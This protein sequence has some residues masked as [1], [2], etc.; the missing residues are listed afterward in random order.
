MANK[1]KVNKARVFYIILTLGL[2]VFFIGSSIGIFY[3]TTVIA[4]APKLDVQKLDSQESTR[5]YDQNGE[6]ITDIGVESRQKVTYEQL[7]QVLIDAFVSIEDSRFFSHNGFDLPRFMMAAIN[8]LKTRSLSQGGSTITMQVIDNAYF[9]EH[10]DPNATKLEKIALKLQEIYLSIK[11]EQL[12]DK[13][14]LF[15]LY[16]NKIN[17][18]AR[19]KGVQKAAEYYFGKSVEE[20]TLPEAA[21]L[22]GVV[23]MPNR[24]NPYINLDLATKRRNEVLHQMVYHGYISKEEEAVAKS[25]K[26][27]NLLVGENT[28]TN[29]PF[30]SYIDAVLDEAQRITG[31]DPA[32]TP[33][34]IYTYMDRDA[35]TKADEILAGVNIPYP[36]N[37]EYFQ[38]AFS[39][40]ETHT[41]NIVALG[42]GRGI[43]VQRGNMRA[44]TMRKQPGSTAKPLLAYSMAFDQL[45]WATSHV[46]EDKPITYRGT[47]LLLPNVDGAYLGEIDLNEAVARSRNTS[48][49]LTYEMLADKLGTQAL[50]QQIERFGFDTPPSFNLGYVIGAASFEVSPTQLAS[51]YAVFANEGKHI[52]PHTIRRIVFLQGG[53]PVEPSYLPTQVISPESAY[54]TSVLLQGAVESK[55]FNY[56]QILKNPNFKVYAKTGTTDY[57]NDAE[58]KYGIPNNAMKDKW[59]NAYTSEY[60]VAVWTGYDTADKSGPQ[61]YFTQAKSQLNVPVTIAKE[62]LFFLHRKNYPK[63]IAPTNNITTITHVLGTFPYAAPTDDMDPSSI[64][65]GYI[66]KENDKLTSISPQPL[67]NLNSFQ[68]QYQQETNTLSFEFAPYPDQ[69][70]T[71]PAS[72]TI[73]YEITHNLN[74]KDI[75]LKAQG[76][77]L[78]DPKI[79]FGSAV[80]KVELV[81]NGSVLYTHQYSTPTS[82]IQVPLL[83][84]QSV[85]VCGYYGLSI[86]ESVTSNRICVDVTIPNDFLPDPGDGEGGIGGDTGTETTAPP[87]DIIDPFS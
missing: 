84:V 15:E 39:V 53:E 86:A 4:D 31:K 3:I 10:A 19:A 49:M 42:N 81:A 37:D 46:V 40:V 43:Q 64:V 13:K 72:S 18:G 62:M 80:Y 68:A 57:G 71:L 79:Y 77:R 20:I 59:V 16:I 8:N 75:V 26:I 55:W 66:K 28:G 56:M 67:S 32:S 6:L 27:E 83:P 41:G 1:R 12:V 87:T 22:A 70:R 63:P 76:R 61:P 54:M 65:T 73:D 85:Q 38:A 60:S 78:F 25:V 5:I 33:M 47:K 52:E 35:Q 11:A 7:P 29:L 45:G 14:E 30:Q 74:N 58:K 69:D 17:F 34:E 9:L 24:L 51:A 23:N 36:K 48:A 21:M 2:S 44:I 82:S 50:I